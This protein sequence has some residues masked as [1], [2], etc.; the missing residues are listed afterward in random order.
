M[1]EVKEKLKNA[2]LS[3][4]GLKRREW[5]DVKEYIDKQF[6]LQFFNATK[7]QALVIDKDLLDRC[8]ET[9]RSFAYKKK[10]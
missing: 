7:E 1:S 5:Q 3:L 4:E 9:M 2:I 6:D 10:V 8:A